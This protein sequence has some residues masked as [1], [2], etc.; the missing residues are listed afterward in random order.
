MDVIYPS[1]RFQNGLSVVSV[2]IQVRLQEGFEVIGVGLR[3]DESVVESNAH[4]LE[5]GVGYVID[6]KCVFGSHCVPPAAFCN[7]DSISK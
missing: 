5:E 6:Q 3:T 1:L 2:E 4:L 7:F